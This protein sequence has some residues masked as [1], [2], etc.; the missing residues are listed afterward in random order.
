VGWRKEKESEGS[1]LSPQAVERGQM[2]DGKKVRTLRRENRG[3]RE[4]K[5]DETLLPLIR[6]I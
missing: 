1:C 6:T 2:E 5:E 3:K 4:G